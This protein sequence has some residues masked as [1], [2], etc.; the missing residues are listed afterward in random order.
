MASD[1]PRYSRVSDVLD[2][3]VLM[4]SKVLGITL[5]DISKELHVTRRTAERIRDA[6]ILGLPQINEIETVGKEKHWGFISGYM[7]NEIINFSPDEIAVLE[8]IKENLSEDKKQ[9]VD[10]I[11]TK[12]KAHSR[13]QITKID[14][15][16]ELILKSEGFAV[17]QKP[18]YKID[19]QILDT[20]RQAIKQN[21]MIRCKY[22][23][24][25]KT[26][27]PYGIIYGSN[28]YL[29]AVEDG[30]PNP[31][32]YSMHKLSDVQISNKQFDKGDFDIKE[33]ANTS[34]GVYHNEIMKVELLFTPDVAEDVLNFNF[35][36]T[37]KVKQN[38]DG[39]VTV[40]FKA[41]G[42]LEILWHIFKWGNNVKIVAPTKLKKMYVE[43]LENV[44]KTE[45]NK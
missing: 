26:L 29:I 40:K 39:S 16:I 20:I 42:E 34:F 28:T 1:K 2:L 31:Y 11:L 8:G 14:D 33:Y 44:L 22:L 37:Q 7:I 3:I 13:K 30:K 6:L 5:N 19:I 35:H 23:G 36:P 21:V 38:E 9:V 41:S 12:L 17:S 45:R 15:A 10:K 18:S 25:N 4:Q 27:A 32:V 24:N 43:Y